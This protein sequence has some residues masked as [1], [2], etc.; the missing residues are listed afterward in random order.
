MSGRRLWPLAS[1]L[2][3]TS[4]KRGICN[5][6]APMTASFASGVCNGG[7]AWPKN[8]RCLQTDTA[9]HQSA[10]FKFQACPMW[11]G[12]SRP[13]SEA[14]CLLSPIPTPA[15]PRTRANAHT[16]YSSAKWPLCIAYTIYTPGMARSAIDQIFSLQARTIHRCP[17]N[18]LFGLSGSCS[19]FTGAV[20]ARFLTLTGRCHSI[21]KSPAGM[22]QSC[23]N[24]HEKD[25]HR[26][27]P[28]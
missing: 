13:R 9:P 12:D 10:N 4:R 16:T 11:P 25:P 22:Q 5:A 17:M 24:L 23:V 3:T 8:A 15:P 20:T 1:P 2:H 28:P 27:R 26:G 21:S 6:S 7:Q 14:S 18:G 19:R